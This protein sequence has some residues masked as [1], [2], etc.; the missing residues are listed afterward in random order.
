M[1]RRVKNGEKLVYCI[2]PKCGTIRKMIDGQYN[3]IK[4]GYERNG[5]ARFCCLN[6]GT[7]FNEKSGKAMSWYERK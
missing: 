6:C 3:I 7:W 2:C 1:A 5:L 4:K